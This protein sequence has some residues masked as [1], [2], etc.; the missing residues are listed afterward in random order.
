MENVCTNQ[1]ANLAPLNHGAVC[2]CAWTSRLER[3]M[4]RGV[5]AHVLHC[6]TRMI[7]SI[8]STIDRIDVANC[9]AWLS[10]THSTYQ[11][12]ECEQ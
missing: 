12:N 9:E 5:S 10:S 11:S 3:T 6:N 2:M 8:K 1:R 7:D 4:L